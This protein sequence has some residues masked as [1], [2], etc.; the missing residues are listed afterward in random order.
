MVEESSEFAAIRC[1]QRSTEGMSDPVGNLKRT[2]FNLPQVLPFRFGQAGF[3]IERLEGRAASSRST[4][5]PNP[6]PQDDGTCHGQRNTRGRKPDR[7]ASQLTS[8][9]PHEWFTGSTAL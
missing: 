5:E 7:M 1:R 2:I 6:K 4:L 8:I 3:G 9:L